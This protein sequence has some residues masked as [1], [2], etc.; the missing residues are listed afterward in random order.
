MNLPS[1]SVKDL[2]VG[3]LLRNTDREARVHGRITKISVGKNG[4]TRV[5]VNPD[6]KSPTPL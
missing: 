3:D 6:D 4:W 2:S 1:S 5:W